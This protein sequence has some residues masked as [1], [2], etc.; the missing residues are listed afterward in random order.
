LLLADLKHAQEAYAY[1]D[2]NKKSG[3]CGLCGCA[4]A[5]TDFDLHPAWGPTRWMVKGV[6]AWREANVDCIALLQLPGASALLWV[7]DWM[8]CKNLGSD[9][10]LYGSV[11]DFMCYV[12]IAGDPETILIRIWSFIEIWYK[13]HDVQN[14]FSN[15]RLSMFHKQRNFAVLRGRAAELRAFGRPLLWAFTKFMDAANVQH[16]W[17]ARALEASNRMED[18]YSDEQYKQSFKLPAALAAE[19]NQC[20]VDYC[21]NI[22]GLRRWCRSQNLLLFKVT[23]KLHFLR[24]IC[25]LAGFIH[26]RL[27][28]CWS[29]E[30]LMH[31]MQRLIQSTLAGTS[32]RN[33]EPKAML[34]YTAAL[35]HAI[36]V[37]EKERDSS[38]L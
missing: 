34:K 16:Q 28:A 26:P 6:T 11:L 17:I 15:V 21:R 12:M 1:P 10:E 7:P 3:C 33:V 30:D 27:A 14:K 4:L 31:H 23:T 32:T 20:C 19:L 2:H 22:A 36:S 18:I 24:E 29:G 5:W 13:D 8:H 38:L 37:Y 9:K 25:M 35:G